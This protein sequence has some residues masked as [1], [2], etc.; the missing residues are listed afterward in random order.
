MT[1]QTIKERLLAE[2]EALP[3]E[4]LREVLDFVEHLRGKPQE[5]ETR[6][7]DPQRDPLRK[8]I[9]GV[10]HGALAHRID[11]ELYDT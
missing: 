7:L 8:F 6:D 5:E 9:G 1:A 2:L 10:E 11:E 4:R 3:E